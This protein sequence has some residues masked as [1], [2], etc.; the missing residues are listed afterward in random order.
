[1]VTIGY[2]DI[3]ST[4]I[5]L[6]WWWIVLGVVAGLV[7]LIILSIILYKCGFFRRNRFS[8]DPTLTGNIVEQDQEQKQ[9][10]IKKHSKKK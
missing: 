4:E 10:L 1:M 5:K 3:L 8:K 9:E 7:L 2:P 6:N